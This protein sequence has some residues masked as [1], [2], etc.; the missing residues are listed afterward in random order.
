M[1]ITFCHSSQLC[2]DI[3]KKA[4]KF[5]LF[6]LSNWQNTTRTQNK[7]ILY[8]TE[9]EGRHARSTVPRNNDLQNF[10]VDL[11]VLSV[12]AQVADLPVFVPEEEK[13]KPGECLDEKWLSVDGDCLLTVAAGRQSS[14]PSSPIPSPFYSHKEE[15]S[16]HVVRVGT[17]PN[18][19]ALSQFPWG[20][21]CGHI[22]PAFDKNSQPLGRRWS[23][24]V[25][26]R[27]KAGFTF[28]ESDAVEVLSLQEPVAAL[29]LPKQGDYLI[30][31]KKLQSWWEN[32][33]EK[34]DGHPP[35]CW[36]FFA[37][38]HPWVFLWWEA[39]VFLDPSLQRR[40]NMILS[41]F[42]V[43]TTW[44]LANLWNESN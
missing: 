25:L 23:W 43:E 38:I 44:K 13:Q 39:G 22:Q 14:N 18:L 15:T 26:Q 7:S 32:E 6:Q 28:T 8:K 16:A 27:L 10:L 29:L 33:N 20:D 4:K 41:T 34:H 2:W 24:A 21:H 42:D 5:Q 31:K 36:R 37:H 12:D 11:H 9:A 1:K 35:L 19:A 3:L 30:L 40:R 17:H